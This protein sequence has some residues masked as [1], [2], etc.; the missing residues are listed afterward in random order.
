MSFPFGTDYD[1][2]SRPPATVYGS[3]RGDRARAVLA[4][5][6]VLVLGVCCAFSLFLC[7]ALRLLPDQA[8]TLR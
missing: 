4:A 1:P 8:V 2:P 3:R 7:A 6:A 5:L